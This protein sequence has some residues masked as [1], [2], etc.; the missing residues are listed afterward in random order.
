MTD[1]HADI[2]ARTGELIALEERWSR[3]QLP[4]AARG[5]GLGRGGVG[6][7]RRGPPLHRHAL[8]VL[9]A[10]LRAPASGARR[11][12][13]RAARP[14][15]ADLAR[16]AQRPVRPVRARPRRTRR[17]GD[18]AADEHRCRGRG[19]GHQGRPQVGLPGQGR[20]RGPGQD[21]RVLGQLPRPDHHDRVVL[22][23]PVRARRLRPLHPR[24]RHR[25]VR[26][27][28]RSRDL[29]G[30]RRRHRRLPRRA[31]AGRGGRGRARPTATCARS[32]SC[33]PASACS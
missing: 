18:G 3:A 8:G 14:P 12:R 17:H 21:R 15:H 32:A 1:A 10:E 16:R 29:P 22:G 33:A 2:A 7:R 4:P 9:G 20:R 13:S 30:S 5:R 28:G 31:R 6:D 27:R 11:R 26:R 23:R 25:P 24:L 19:D